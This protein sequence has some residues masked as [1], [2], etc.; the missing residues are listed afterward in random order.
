MKHLRWIFSL[1]L[2]VFSTAMFAQSFYV[3]TNVKSYDP[4]ISSPP[5][6]VIHNEEILEEMR[7]MSKELKVNIKDHPSSVLAFIIEKV[8]I[9]KTME[10]FSMKNRLKR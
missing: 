2:F 4:L 10:T 6:L 9:A 7:E 1:W 5:E 8:S 3:L